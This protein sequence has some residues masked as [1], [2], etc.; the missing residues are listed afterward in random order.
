[1]T[2]ETAVFAPFLEA[3][4]S[5]FSAHL[6]CC[7]SYTTMPNIRENISMT[8]TFPKLHLKTTALKKWMKYKENG[9]NLLHHFLKTRD[10]A[11]LSI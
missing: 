7:C 2:G 1:M 9:Q 4:S 11:Y 3:A 5:I 10:D 6:L 8:F